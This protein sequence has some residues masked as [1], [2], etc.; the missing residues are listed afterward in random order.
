MLIPALVLCLFAVAAPV[1]ATIALTDVTL[2][3]P[4]VPLAPHQGLTADTRISIIPSGA[5]TFTSG[6]TL[7]LETDLLDA[8]WNTVVLTDGIP[9]DT[10]S[11]QGSVMFLNGFILSY[12]TNRDVALEVTVAGTVP[13]GV[14]STTVLMV[15]ELDNS[16]TPVPGSTATVT[17]PVLAPAPTRVTTPAPVTAPPSPSPSPPSPAPTRAGVVPLLAVLAAILA[18]GLPRMRP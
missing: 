13:D 7:Q 17:E 3:P 11:G 16:G 1:S 18:T 12:P 5:R 4:D 6:H 14:S 8:R 10:E 15:K 2:T 9:A